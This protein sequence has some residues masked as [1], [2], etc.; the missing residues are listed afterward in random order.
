MDGTRLKGLVLSVNHSNY[1]ILFSTMITGSGELI[2]EEDENG[3]P[4]PFLTTEQILTQLEKFGF[5]IKYDVKS[6]L[7]NDVLAYLSTMY[8]LGY[9]K[10]NRIGVRMPNQNGDRYNRPTVILMKDVSDNNNLLKFDQVISQVEFNKKLDANIVVNITDE[11]ESDSWDWVT[12][13]ANLEDILEENIDPKD[14]YETQT[15]VKSGKQRK[16]SD[17]ITLIDYTPYDSELS[18]DEPTEIAPEGY[19][20]YTGD[21]DDDDESVEYDSGL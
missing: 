12:Y 4:I 21:D 3:E 6:N 9:V 7:S 17:S 16:L 8:N 15:D 20:P 2:S 14:D 13:M 19:T 5:I 18:D 1:G 10:I 11:L